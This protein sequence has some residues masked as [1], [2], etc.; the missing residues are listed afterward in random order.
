MSA[1]LLLD[2]YLTSVPNCEQSN[3]R[4]RARQLLPS[5]RTATE[6]RNSSNGLANGESQASRLI[7]G[8]NVCCCAFAREEHREESCDDS[9]RSK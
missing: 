5:C 8:L 2:M 6:Q 3:G 4:P 9:F 7:P 1:L